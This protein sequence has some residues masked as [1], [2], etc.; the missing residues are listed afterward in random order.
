MNWNV[1][2]SCPFSIVLRR[3]DLLP[4]AISAYVCFI[5]RSNVMPTNATKDGAY[6]RRD[7][8]TGGN[9]K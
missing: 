6:L 1:V 4:R 8:R 7:G 5:L 9:Y 3:R 2:G